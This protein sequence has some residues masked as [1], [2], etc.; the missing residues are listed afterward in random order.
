[1]LLNGVFM[2][3]FNYL[4]SSVRIR[5]LLFRIIVSIF[6]FFAWYVLCFIVGLAIGSDF[7]IDFSY[8][9]MVVGLLAELLAITTLITGYL[10]NHFGAK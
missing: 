4:L 10:R 7:G 8:Y 3:L 2:K 9:L 1:M 5:D 6:I